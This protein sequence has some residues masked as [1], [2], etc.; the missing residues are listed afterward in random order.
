M[1]YTKKTFVSAT[2]LKGGHGG[3]APHVLIPILRL[4][5]NYIIHIVGNNIAVIDEGIHKCSL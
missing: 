2:Q 1:L 5:A 4:F 3:L